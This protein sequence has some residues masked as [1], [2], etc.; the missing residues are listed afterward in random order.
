[1]QSEQRETA[2]GSA[3]L[4]RTARKYTARVPGSGRVWVERLMVEKALGTDRAEVEKAWADARRAVK[5]SEAEVST[6]WAWG[7]ITL[8]AGDSEEDKRRVHEVQSRAV[9]V[10]MS[11]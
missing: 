7:L 6:I 10:G 8:I 3:K 9:R 2:E 11:Y 4:L 1:M 5:G